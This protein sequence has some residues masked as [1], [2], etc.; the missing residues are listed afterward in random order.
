VRDQYTI[1]RYDFQRAYVVP[2]NSLQN[3][4]NHHSTQ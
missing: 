4:L 1:S 2:K 3:D